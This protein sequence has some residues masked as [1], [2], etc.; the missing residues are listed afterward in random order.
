MSKMMR[1]SELIASKW[2]GVHVGSSIVSFCDVCGCQRTMMCTDRYYIGG[3]WMLVFL[4]DH[5]RFSKQENFGCRE[6][7]VCEVEDVEL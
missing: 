1:E 4:C 6:V 3:D 5:C 2:F 7:D